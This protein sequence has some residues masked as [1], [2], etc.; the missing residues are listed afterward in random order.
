[1]GIVFPGL[2]RPFCGGT[3]IGPRHVL[4]AS[5]CVDESLYF[6]VIVGEHEVVYDSS[7]GTRHKVCGMTGHPLYDDH[8]VN[9][10]FAILRLKKPVELGPRAVPAC[11]ANS[12]MAGDT[13]TDETVTVSGWGDLEEDSY[14]PDELHS[15][16]IQVTSNS[17]CKQSHANEI[18]TDA[19]LCAGNGTYGGIDTCQGDS[20][21]MKS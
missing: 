5:H 10:D 4:T 8:T 3:L 17:D 15:A 1:M 20:G 6:E 13:L 19:M 14:G 11:L 2:I 9:Y 12:S 18:I 21:G 7:D 16:D